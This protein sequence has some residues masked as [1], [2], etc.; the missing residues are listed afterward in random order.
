MYVMEFL[1]KSFTDCKDH[2]ACLSYDGTDAPTA[3]SD[4]DRILGKTLSVY[5]CHGVF[6]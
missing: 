5:T 2:S 4:G 3:E 6:V 1:H